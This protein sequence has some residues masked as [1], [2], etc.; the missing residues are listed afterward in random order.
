MKKYLF[1]ILLVIS[2]AVQAG[3]PFKEAGKNLM[4]LAAYVV[5]HHEGLKS[6]FNEEQLN[7]INA[8]AINGGQDIKTPLLALSKDCKK[9]IILS[10]I[11]LAK[12]E[13]EAHLMDANSMHE[14]AKKTLQELNFNDAQLQLSH[15]MISSLLESVEQ[16]QKVEQ[17]VVEQK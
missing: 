12:I 11:F 1:P 6:T 10:H 3:N 13:R 9:A 2:G 8:Y 15:G 17:P 7:K 5:N 16:D 4:S 14:M